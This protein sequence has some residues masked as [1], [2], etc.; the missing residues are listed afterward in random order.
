MQSILNYFRPIR[1]SHE[2]DLHAGLYSRKVLDRVYRIFY[3]LYFIYM[4]YNIWN[5]TAGSAAENNLGCGKAACW[6]AT[7]RDRMVK[8]YGRKPEEGD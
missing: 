7:F 4:L 2:P 6:T 1:C 3:N 8:C 5:A